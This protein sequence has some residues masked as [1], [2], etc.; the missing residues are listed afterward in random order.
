MDDYLRYWLMDA[1][2]THSVLGW[3]GVVDEERGGVVA[4]FGE[5]K[6]A[7]EY[8][9]FLA[10]K[11]DTT[12]ESESDGTGGQDRESYS[13]DQDRDNYVPEEQDR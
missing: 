13:D 2:D 5:E 10:S 9:C 8:L 1:D 4:Y 3:T 12:P 7:E 11:E 6:D